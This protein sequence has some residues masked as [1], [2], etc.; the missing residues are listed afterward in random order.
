[1]G[2]GCVFVGVLVSVLVLTLAA[3]FS[4]SGFDLELMLIGEI[5]PSGFDSI[6]T[7]ILICGDGTGESSG[8]LG[9]CDEEGGGVGCETA[10]TS[11][12]TRSAFIRICSCIQES[13]RSSSGGQNE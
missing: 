1:M 3:P 11:L 4:D 5:M 12:S 8:V 7:S 2:M 6:S 9:C 13:L 10:E